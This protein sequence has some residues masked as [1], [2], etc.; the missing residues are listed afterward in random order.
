MNNNFF[1]FIKK[2]FYTLTSNILSLLISTSVVL[3]VPKVIGVEEYGYWQ[4]YLFYSSYVGFFHLGWNDGIYLRYGGEE[5]TK[6]DKKLFHTQFFMEFV[7]QTIIL[8]CIIIFSQ[9]LVA[10]PEKKF[11]FVMFGICMVLMNLQGM[12]SFVLQATNRIKEYSLITIIN[13]LCYFILL[14]LFLLIGER[15]YKF[16]IFADLSGRFLGLLLAVYYCKDIVFNRVSSFLLNVKEAMAN[17]NAGIKLMFANIAS[18]LIIGIVRLGI[19]NNWSIE[20]FGKVSLTLSISNMMMIFINAIGVVIFPTLRRLN[21][22]RYKEVYLLIRDVLVIASFGLLMIY[23][24][25]KT[26][27]AV[28]LPE[29]SDALNYMAILFP[30]FI[31]EGKTSLLINTFLK[32]LRKEK[33]MLFI[34]VS[35][36]FMSLIFT[37][38]STYILGSLDLAI[39]SIVMLLACRSIIAEFYVAKFLNLNVKKDTFLELFLTISFIILGWYVNSIVTPIMYSIFYLGYLFIKKEDIKQSLKTIKIISTKKN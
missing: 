14:I 34:N 35:V 13:R 17:V 3:I 21:K 5:Y 32:T 10:D 16:M 12:L 15:L 19:E 6:L 22:N 11:I 37:I 39:F 4:L 2:I 18:M 20:T 7:L 30:I 26:V 29:Y 23:Y 24:P 8:I 25:L 9:L 28:W 33:N 36:V 1:Q 31:Y 27:L 38:I